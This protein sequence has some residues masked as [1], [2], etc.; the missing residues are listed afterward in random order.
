MN[1]NTNRSIR[2]LFINIALLPPILLSVV[3]VGQ[4]IGISSGLSVL[5]AIIIWI[6]CI[7]RLSIHNTFF[8]T[9]ILVIIAAIGYLAQE[10]SN[11]RDW[12]AEIA[13][14]PKINLTG[15]FLKISNLR[16][17]NWKSISEHEESWIQSTYDLNDLERLDVIVVPF[18]PSDLMAHVMLSFGFKGGQH[19]ALSIEARLEE[20]EPYSLIGGAARQLELIYL[21]GTEPDLLGLR[22]FHRKNQVFLYPLDVPITFA[23]DLLL[24]LCYAA[25]Q[26][27]EKP[28][29]YATLRH[30]C[31]TTLLRHASRITESPVGFSREILFPAKLGELL[32]RFELLD[33]D[34]NWNEVKDGFRVDQR[35]SLKNNRADFSQILRMNTRNQ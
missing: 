15:D 22:I 5:A 18:G 12:K 24:E 16:D 11:E 20:G 21:F 19:L 30:N 33:T 17:F 32:H 26:L 4:F 13:R 8:L 2:F 10:P 7:W 23:E 27:H 35:V 14:L 3:F 34:P 29:F 9:A 6:L 25:N 28:K 31:T 1:V